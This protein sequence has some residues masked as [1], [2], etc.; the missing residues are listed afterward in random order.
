MAYSIVR[1]DNLQ[2]TRSGALKSVKYY[3][4]STATAIENGNVVA[5][6][7]L[8]T[9]EREIFK[10]VAPAA[11]GDAVV[12]V[13]GVELIYDE[14]TMAKGLDD[15]IN[16]AGKP[17]R[18]YELEKGDLFSVSDSAI[19]ALANN[20]PV[21]GNVVVTK[22]SST[23]LEEKASAAGTESLVCKVI[24]K[25]VFGTRAIPMTVLQVIKA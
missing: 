19:V 10:G 22:A 11:V 4:S 8:D 21:V 25:E 23:K 9:N 15:Y 12:L 14:S 20:T 13:A 3:V 24:A 6:S 16:K 17:F 7:G 18:A 2:A 5:L 1:T